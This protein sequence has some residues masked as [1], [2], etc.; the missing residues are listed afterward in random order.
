M[1][2]EFVLT[3]PVKPGMSCGSYDVDGLKDLTTG[4]VGM[5][6]SPCHLES[7]YVIIIRLLQYRQ[8]LSLM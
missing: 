6:L 7:L 3:P 5:I 1:S 8:N 2:Y 4:G